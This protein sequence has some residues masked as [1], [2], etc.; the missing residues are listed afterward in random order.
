MT[1]FKKKFRFRKDVLE[2]DLR[3]KKKFN[4]WWLLLLLILLLP[5]LLLVPF[6]KDIN[7]KANDS[8]STLMISGTVAI[9]G[10]AGVGVG[11]SIGVLNSNVSATVAGGA[12]HSLAGRYKAEF[13]QKL[14]AFMDRR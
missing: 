2:Y 5:L 3:L 1:S 11:L 8:L 10:T 6:K 7:V 12:T 14:L 9:G 13:M 4:W